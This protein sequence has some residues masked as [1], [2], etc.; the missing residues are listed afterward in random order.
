MAAKPLPDDQTVISTGAAGPVGLRSITGSLTNT[1]LAAEI[2]RSL[3][4]RYQA[5]LNEALPEELAALVHQL[6]ER[7]EQSGSLRQ[8]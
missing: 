2:G 6:Q 8:G 7:E 4:S 1:Q 3:Q 5:S